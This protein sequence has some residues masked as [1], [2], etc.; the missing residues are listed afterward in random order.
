MLLPLLLGALAL[1]G[2]SRLVWFAE[3][4]DE[5]V[6]GVVRYTENGAQHA[7]ALIPLALLALA[8]VAGVL[9][10]GGWLRRVLGGLLALAGVAGI[11]TG[12]TGVRFGFAAGLPGGQILLAHG[13]AVLGGLL[14]ALG[15]LAAVKWAGT[16]KRLGA[17]Y[18]APGA[19]RAR[20][21]P[22]TELW[23]AL[24][25][26]TDPTDPAGQPGTGRRSSGG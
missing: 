12:A 14:L 5:G 21:D 15:G 19:Q 8:G 17:K 2:S 18:S 4:R 26:G 25:G 16:A 23:E 3:F 7:T 11:W 22:D 1:W 20:R 10:T 9:A 6:R 24:S 13:L